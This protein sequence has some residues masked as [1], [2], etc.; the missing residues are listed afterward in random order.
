MDTCG[1]YSAVRPGL[2][3]QYFQRGNFMDRMLQRREPNVNY[4]SGVP[5]SHRGSVWRRLV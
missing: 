2:Q 3:A 1:Q 5:G 4:V